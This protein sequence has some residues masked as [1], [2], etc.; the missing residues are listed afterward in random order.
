MTAPL[1]RLPRPPRMAYCRECGQ[2]FYPRRHDQTFCVDACRRKRNDRER[3]QGRTAL[4]LIMAW[5]LDRK[6]GALAALT[7]FADEVADGERKRRREHAA[8]R[9][10]V[11]RSKA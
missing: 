11:E 2:P 10:Q 7:R 3:S 4:P 6:A 8:I 5:R 1:A 9:D